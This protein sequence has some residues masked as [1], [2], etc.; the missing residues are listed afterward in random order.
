MHTYPHTIENGFGEQLTFLRV[1]RDHNGDRLE[2]RYVLSLAQ[3]RPC[4]CIIS[5]KRP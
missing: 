2:S 1:V 3:V 5:R 4:T